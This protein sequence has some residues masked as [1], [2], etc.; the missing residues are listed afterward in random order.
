V[1]YLL[2]RASGSILSLLSKER[3]LCGFDFDGTLV[4]I[5]AHPNDAHLSESTRGLLTRLEA[6]YPCIIISGRS[7]G[8]LARKLEGVT[9][10][11]L[12]GSHGADGGNSTLTNNSRTDEWRLAFERETISMP[13]VWVENK[14]R[15]LAVHYR[16]SKHGAEARRRIL[17]VAGQLDNARVFGGKA[18]INVAAEG[19]QN[20]GDALAAERDRLGCRWVLFVGDDEND[21]EAFALSGNVVSVRIGRKKA[22]R[23]RY[24]LRNQLEIDLLLETLVKLRE[25]S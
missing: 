20:K 25:I 15:S 2:S 1:K 23:A 11:R 13:G 12:V 7:R 9:V 19:D 10:E 14:G 5:V 21:E 3:T 6:L 8:D 22:S 4:P 17:Q 16:Q 18:V 24:F